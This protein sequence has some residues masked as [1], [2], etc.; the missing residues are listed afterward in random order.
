MRPALLRPLVAVLLLAAFSPRSSGLELAHRCPA[1]EPG[2]HGARHE[3]EG[4]RP[5]PGTAD[6]CGCVGES[7]G[8]SV[9]VPVARTGLSAAGV[10][11]A[12]HGPLLAPGS[13]ARP[14]APHLLPFAQG[15]PA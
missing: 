9:L 6:R 15:P 5:P 10:I 13:P 12:S 8:A 4:H 2:T 14:A 1:A 11:L 7:C 3:G